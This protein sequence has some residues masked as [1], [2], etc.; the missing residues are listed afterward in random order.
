M[1]KVDRVL[2]FILN[3]VESKVLG[4]FDEGE[5]PCNVT[6]LLSVMAPAECLRRLCKPQAPILSCHSLVPLP[7]ATV[8]EGVDVTPV[9]LL[10]VL[11]ANFRRRRGRPR[12]GSLTV[13]FERARRCEF[14]GREK[15]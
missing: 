1:Q 2:A 4:H 11:T 12:P 9:L 15:V 14:G 7:S 13:A 3:L 6:V 5:T 8:L 10:F